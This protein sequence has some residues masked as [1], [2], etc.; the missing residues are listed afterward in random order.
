MSIIEKIN[1]PKIGQHPHI[2]CRR[3]GYLVATSDSKEC[4]AC[5]ESTRLDIPQR[6][7]AC[8][9]RKGGARWDQGTHSKLYETWQSQFTH[10]ALK[11]QCIKNLGSVLEAAGSSW[12]K[13]VKVNVYLKDMDNFAAMNEVYEK[14]RKPS[15]ANIG[16]PTSS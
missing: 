3:T 10:T 14:V 11:A 13:V 12:E 5:H 6:P 15:I 1:S 2:L 9:G 8:R 16:I 4:S 7:N